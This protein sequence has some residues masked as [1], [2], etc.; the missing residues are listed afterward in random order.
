MGRRLSTA[1]AGLLLAAP[2]A[3]AAEVRFDGAYQLRLNFNNNYLLDPTQRLDQTAWAEHRLRL[4]PKIVEQTAIEI[5]AQFDVVSGLFAGDRAPTFG[6]LGW[7]ERS[8]QNGIRARG[9]DFRYL[10]AS[11]RLPVGLLQVGQ[12]PNHWG[13]GLVAN[14]GECMDCV[15]FGDLRFGDI[16]DGF[17]FG[18]RPLTFLGPRS[19]LAQQVIAAV[20]GQI[21]YRD[22]YASLVTRAGGGLAFNDFALQGVGILRW[23]PSEMSRIGFYAARRS[24]N[25]AA[26]GGNLHAWVFDAHART[27]IILPALQSSLR[28]EAEGAEIYGGT[29]HGANLNGAETRI[30][31]QGFA[32]RATVTRLD[33]EAELEVGY[34]SGDE[35]PLDSTANGFAANRDYKVG[36]VLWDEVMLFQT[37]N[38]A[39]RL[40][41]PSLSGRPPGGIDSIPTEGAVTNAIYLNPRARFRRPFF[42]GSLRAVVGVL[43]TRA[44]QPVADAYQSFLSSSPL[45]S[46]G[47]PAGRNYGTELD[48]GLSW[49]VPFTNDRQLGLEVGGQ[50]GVLFPGDVFLRGDGTNMPAISAFRFRSNLYF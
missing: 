41:D 22:R 35:N 15:D 21:I 2:A 47:M 42:G 27:E 32:V 33:V 29:G 19:E 13:M 28:L 16:V 17:L 30:A 7:T 18:T 24:Q 11:I 12:M 10:F 45:N 4:T 37:Q 48:L 8:E 3:R 40:A 26:D 44:P 25:Y 31:Q 43:F 5:Q 39:R 50:Y 6:E 34:M 23:E 9:F 1:L 14:N 49:R 36:L 38:A 46:F 20:S